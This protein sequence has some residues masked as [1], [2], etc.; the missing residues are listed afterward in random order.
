[1]RPMSPLARRRT[2]VAPSRGLKYRPCPGRRLVLAPSTGRR[3]RPPTATRGRCRPP[4]RRSRPLVIPRRITDGGRVRAERP[5][6]WFR[7]CP[8]SQDTGPVRCNSRGWSNAPGEKSGAAPR[9]PPPCR[10]ACARVRRSRKPRPCARNASS[11]P[12]APSCAACDVSRPGMPAPA[13]PRRRPGPYT[14]LPSSLP[15]PPTF[16]TNNKENNP[17]SLHLSEASTTLAGNFAPSSFA[18]KTPRE[19]TGPSVRLRFG[20]LWLPASLPRFAIPNRST[21]VQNLMTPRAS[22]TR[23]RPFFSTFLQ[24]LLVSRRLGSGSRRE[25]GWATRATTRPVQ[26]MRLCRASRRAECGCRPCL[27]RSCVESGDDSRRKRA[28]R[29]GTG[30]RRGRSRRQT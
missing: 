15:Y 16:T 11:P 30:G 4:P 21:T 22:S 13:S 12:S 19:I 8:G 20:A 9:A 17:Y 25:Q 14:F 5:Q 7:S 3:P 26:P 27:A 29:A 23:V 6:S 10:T 24:D 1:M 28:R 2:L 18:F